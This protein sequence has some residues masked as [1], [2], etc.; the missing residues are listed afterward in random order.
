MNPR[1]CRPLGVAPLGCDE[2]AAFWQTLTDSSKSLN[3]EE[4]T[5]VW[6][7]VRTTAR[8]T[9]DS[10][11]PDTNRLRTQIGEH[12]AFVRRIDRSLGIA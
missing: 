12:A 2:D 4:T 8:L 11:W 10:D 1:P 6:S 5:R 9:A 3:C 7:P